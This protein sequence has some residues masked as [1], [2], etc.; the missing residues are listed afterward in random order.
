MELLKE[1]PAIVFSFRFSILVLFLGRQ[2]EID[3]FDFIGFPC[4]ALC[5]MQALVFG[6]SGWLENLYWRSLDWE[7][8]MFIRSLELSVTRLGD[9][10]AYQI[11]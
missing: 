8:L 6:R 4:T 9:F 7:V 1:K 3:S 10:D 11:T 2:T 5:T